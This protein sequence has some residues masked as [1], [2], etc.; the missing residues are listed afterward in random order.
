MTIHVMHDL[1]TLDNRPSAA[2]ISI[3]AVAFDP[4]KREIVDRFYQ[5]LDKDDCICHGLTV[6]RDTLNWWLKQS[7]AA[8]AVFSA[9]GRLG[10]MPALMAYS[11]WWRDV[12]AQIVWANG[13][14]FD[15]VIMTYAYDRLQADPPWKF[16]NTRCYRTVKNLYPTEF[17]RTGTHH[18]A[19]DDAEYQANHLFV[20]AETHGIPLK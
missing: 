4:D 6:S 12:D 7:E 3:G 19:V 10:L 15:T 9:P 5:V 14:D 2:I 1:E 20:I 18:N 11:Q 16:Y 13:T 17:P 8:R